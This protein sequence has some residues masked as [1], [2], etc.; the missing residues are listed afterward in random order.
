MSDEGQVRGLDRTRKDRWGHDVPI[1]GV[2]MKQ[3]RNRLGYMMVPLGTGTSKKKLCTVHRL[4]LIAFTEDRPEMQVNHRDG[5]KA[6]NHLSN[7][8]WVTASQNCKHREDMGL[9]IR[10]EKA[11]RG[12]L[13]E[14][15]VI[16]IRSLRALGWT[17]QKIADR[18]CVSQ[19]SIWMIC[20][21]KS[22]AHV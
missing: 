16:E 15:K 6:N 14:E 12:K 3:Q 19:H 8:E 17:Q 20:N 11:P 5:D 7:L 18:Y 10:G 13:T 21:F 22:W 4:V 2:V 1:K 9:G